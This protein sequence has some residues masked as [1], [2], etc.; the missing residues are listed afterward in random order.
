[1][2]L[3]TR[4][5]WMHPLLP[6]HTAS[7]PALPA[8]SESPP[9]GRVGRYQAPCNPQAAPL[10]TFH[11]Q[12]ALVCLGM[13]TFR[14]PS[15]S[16]HTHTKKKLKILGQF[17]RRLRGHCT[18]E[19]QCVSTTYSSI[20][21][22]GL[23]GTAGFG[24]AVGWGW[25]CCASWGGATFSPLPPTPLD[26]SSID[27]SESTMPRNSSFCG[28]TKLIQHWRLDSLSFV[29]FYFEK[30]KGPVWKIGLMYDFYTGKSLI[31]WK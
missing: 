31:H 2:L 13:C 5:S 1:M 22:C 9:V 26:K 28:V 14:K 18:V 6:V 11:S 25:G 19:R 21:T 23:G 12:G 20:L 3:H 27:P 17:V 29:S 16:V 7:R 30:L 8:E 4:D 15:Q 24:A 10:R